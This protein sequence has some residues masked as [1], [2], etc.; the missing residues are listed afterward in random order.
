TGN[1]CIILADDIGAELDPSRYET[2]TALLES[3]G[4]Q[5]FLTTTD[6]HRKTGWRKVE[7]RMFHVEH[8]KIKEVI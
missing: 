1:P 6:P 2:L 5:I 7:Q 8:G 4:V 3:L